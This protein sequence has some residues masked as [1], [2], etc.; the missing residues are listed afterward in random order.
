MQLASQDREVLTSGWLAEGLLNVCEQAWQ[1]FC[2]GVWDGAFA[3]DIF[4]KGL[5][6]EARQ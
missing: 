3:I 5:A 4:F 1:G 2:G 6:T